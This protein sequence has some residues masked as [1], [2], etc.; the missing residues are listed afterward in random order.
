MLSAAI[1]CSNSVL[2]IQPEY[3]EA[4]YNM[5]TAL[6]ENGDLDEAITC[7]Q[8]TLEIQPDHGHAYNNLENALKDKSA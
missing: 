2:E 1:D 3:A 7:Y 4:H 8:W 5:G 6:Q